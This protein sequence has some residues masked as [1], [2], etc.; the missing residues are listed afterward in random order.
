MTRG[1]LSFSVLDT[2]VEAGLSTEYILKMMT[3]HGIRLLGL[4]GER[5]KIQAGQAADI[6]ATLENPLD[7]IHTLKRVSFVMKDGKVFKRLRP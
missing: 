3:T 4:E 1:E 2:Y 6:I 7:N 5:G